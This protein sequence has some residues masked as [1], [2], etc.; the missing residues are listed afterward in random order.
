MAESQSGG[1]GKRAWAMLNQVSKG[2]VTPSRRAESERYRVLLVHAH[3]LGDK[4]Y[5]GALADAVQRGLKEAG[6]SVSTLS[7]YS[8]KFQP[9]LTYDEKDR[10]LKDG[11]YPK[12]SRDV[13]KS[14]DELKKCDALV[15][16]YPT[17]WMNVPGILKGWLDRSFLP[18][19][20]FKIPALEPPE[21]KEKAIAG[22]IPG[23]PNIKKIG[24]VSTFGSS[25]PLVFLAGDNGLNMFS[26]CILPLCNPNCTLQWNGFFEI[27][28]KTPQQRA[29]FIEHVKTIYKDEF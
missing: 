29:D 10:Y 13:Q 14:V 24:I 23:L 7:L 5:S 22:L 17:W 19:V 11:K 1:F 16:V 3:P 25:R 15:F 6:H 18:G 27:D 8:E 2:W 26:R 4:S 12:A 28:A 20:A 9:A 21:E